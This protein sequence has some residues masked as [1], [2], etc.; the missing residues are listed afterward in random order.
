MDESTP[1]RESQAKRDGGEGE[2]ESQTKEYNSASATKKE[3][4]F[5]SLGWLDR[6]LALWILLAMII[7]IL[8]GNYVPNISSAL[9]KGEFVNVSVPIGKS[10]QARRRHRVEADCEVSRWVARHDVSHPVQGAI[11][12]ASPCFPIQRAVDT[13]WFQHHPELDHS[14][15][16]HGMLLAYCD[17]WSC[18]QLT[19][20]KLGLA[21]AFL[22]D[23]EGLREGLI[24][25]GLARCIAMVS[26]LL[27]AHCWPC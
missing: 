19:L 14:A 10:H 27:T 9:H 21:W 3:S 16:A 5:K 15:F 12:D 18:P 8:L 17:L 1:H 6:L 2:L 23:K 11:R 4:A 20:A 22:P 26:E 7:G 25:V 13:D 24:L